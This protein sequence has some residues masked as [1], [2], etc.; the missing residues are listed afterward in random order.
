[1]TEA[2]PGGRA[3]AVAASP[4]IAN[5]GDSRP[6]VAHAGGM[7]RDEPRQAGGLVGVLAVGVAL[8]AAFAG[9]VWT[10]I[11][12]DGRDLPFSRGPEAPATPTPSVATAE[13]SPSPT[14]TWQPHEGPALAFGDFVMVSSRPCLRRLDYDVDGRADRRVSDAVADLR[15]LGDDIPGGVIVHIG[16]NGGAQPQDLDRLMAVLGP[17][18]S[19]VFSTIQIP[20]DPDRFT[21]EEDTNSAIMALPQRYPNVRVLSWNALSLTNPTWINA[22]GSM[23]EEG[24]RAFATFADDVL[25]T[26]R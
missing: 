19:V 25:R 1:M 10:A 6:Q 4:R 3:Y 9:G 15:Q 14:A 18:R 8:M 17:E 16:A 2:P 12:L 26:A 24:C 11:L 20:D 22:D 21:F 13:P 23:T 5:S 7:Y